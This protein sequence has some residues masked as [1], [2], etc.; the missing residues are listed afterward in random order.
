[1][2]KLQ[3]VVLCVSL[4]GPALTEAR[5][6]P[7][8]LLGGPTTTPSGSYLNLT[9]RPARAPRPLIPAARGPRPSARATAQPRVVCG[10]TIVP[11]DSAVDPGMT[12]RVTPPA[13]QPAIRALE[14]PICGAAAAR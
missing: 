4:V 6:A 13:A 5:Q 10:M 2:T 1:M 14:P 12:A 7:R 3:A 11:G 8:P 9:P